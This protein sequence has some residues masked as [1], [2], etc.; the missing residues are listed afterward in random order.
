MADIRDDRSECLHYDNPDFHVQFRKNKIYADDILDDISIHWHD[1]VEFIYVTKGSIRYQM[2]DKIVQIKAGEGIFV[3]SRQL[4]LIVSDH[5]EVTLYCLIFHPMILCSSNYVAEK[6]VS[7]I[8][9]N[10]GICYIML[11]H[12][13]AWQGKML[14]DIERIQ[15]VIGTETEELGTMRIIYGIWETLSSNIVQ[16][17]ADSNLVNHDLVI[18]KEMISY[19]QKH[20]TERVTIKQLCE[21][22]WIG[23]TKCTSLFDRYVN[24]TPM[25]YVK[26]Y[27]IERSIK[28]LRETDKRITDIAYE[29]GFSEGS[30]FSES[31]RQAMGC[32]PQQF[33]LMDKKR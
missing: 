4:H 21:V 5:S 16:Y 1:E 14:R 28:L 13:V 25:Q 26:N 15:G 3:N 10:D 17:S 27:R 11:S 8:V 2:Q 23:K 9:C 29:V 19:I 7:P 24:M 33:R 20:Y 32:S 31:F 30:Y 12:N 18:I 22:G 6:F